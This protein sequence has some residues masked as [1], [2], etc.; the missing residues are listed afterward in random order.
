M[1]RPRRG[2][3]RVVLCGP[4]GS[5]KTTLA[6]RLAGRDARTPP[7]PGSV[8]PPLSASALA[9]DGVPSLV[10]DTPGDLARRDRRATSSAAGPSGRALREACAGADVV[11]LCYDASGGPVDVA[12]RVAALERDWLPLLRAALRPPPPSRAQEHDPPGD[13]NPRDAEPRDADDSDDDSDDRPARVPVAL[14]G[15]KADANRAHLL[16]AH[17]LPAHLPVP[18]PA[19]AA[20]APTARPTPTTHRTDT[21]LAPDPVEARLR[22]LLERW[23]EVAFRAECDARTFDRDGAQS[24]VDA[25]L[26]ATEAAANPS[27]PLLRRRVVDRADAK[28]HGLTRR[29]ASALTRAFHAADVDGDGALSDDELRAYQRRCFGVEL[30]ARELEGIKAVLRSRARAVDGALNRREREPEDVREDERGDGREG[31]RVDADGREGAVGSGEEGVTLSGFLFLHALFVERRRAGTVW[32]A[33][34]AHGYDEN[35]RLVREEHTEDEEKEAHGE[36]V[37]DEEL[38]EEEVGED[39]CED[40]CEDAF[41]DHRRGVLVDSSSTFRAVVLAATA[42]GLFAAAARVARRRD[43]G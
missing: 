21:S 30:P 13:T 6:L 31:G 38:D 8:A 1:G 16:P 9:D 12:D 2:V 35:V 14:V 17:L 26:A 18:A 24:C 37:G 7:S 5:G 27:A 36:D 19:A 15:C 11:L 43:G 3:R 39:V 33:L 4:S 22:G 29:C 25:L 40:V 20:K 42:V 34:R 41:G 32:T 23:R 28:T 10:V